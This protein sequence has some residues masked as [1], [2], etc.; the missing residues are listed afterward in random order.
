M[1]GHAWLAQSLHGSPKPGQIGWPELVLVDVAVVVEP[2]P[3][4][5]VVVVVVLVVV[6]VVDCPLEVEEPWLA[7]VVGPVAEPAPPAP[8]TPPAYEA[9]S[10]REPQP[11]I[12]T[13]PRIEAR[14][15]I[16]LSPRAS[17]MTRQHTC[18]LV[19]APHARFF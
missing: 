8:P 7:S 11:T 16:Q 18:F 10:T 15:I 1:S 6:L 13:S 17:A 14:R 12:R 5:L 2:G 3:P 9:I 4:V 19:A